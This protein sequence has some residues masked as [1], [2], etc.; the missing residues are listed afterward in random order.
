MP[1]SQHSEVGTDD[2]RTAQ[3]ILMYQ[4]R[5]ATSDV[6]AHVI[7]RAPSTAAS[8]S[9][10]RRASRA[11]SPAR[12][13]SSD[14]AADMKYTAGGVR[15]HVSTGN[16]AGRSCRG[17]SSDSSVLESAP[18]TVMPV[19]HPQLDNAGTILNPTSFMGVPLTAEGLQ[20]PPFLPAMQATGLVMGLPQ[21]PVYPEEEPNDSLS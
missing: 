10:S 17:S 21:Q 12:S 4:A 2:F 1:E 18:I 5:F 11:T 6:M 7:R 15:G 3:R 19:A 9:P 14:H 13:V 16:L 20:L 8:R